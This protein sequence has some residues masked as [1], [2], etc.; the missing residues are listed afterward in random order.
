MNLTTK[1]ETATLGVFLRDRRARLAPDAGAVGHRRTPGLRREEV[2][3]R[4]GVSVTW[5]TWLEQGRGGPPSDEVL[6]RLARALELDAAGREALFLLGRQRPPPIEPTP[7]SPVTPAVQ[8]VLDGLATSP[9]FVKTAAWDVVAWNEAACVVFG[10]YDAIP[11]AERNGLR[12]LFGDPAHRARLP[13]WED[14]ARFAAGVLRLDVTRG[15]PDAVALAAE[16]LETNAEFRR[17]WGASEVRTQGSGL[18]RMLVQDAGL[19]VFDYA[20]FAI[21]AAPGL[22]MMVF[23]PLAA[24]DAATIAALVARRAER[25][26]QGAQAQ[27]GST[28]PFS[29]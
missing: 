4:A 15:F 3:A 13:D 23:S 16:L 14:I 28:Q 24:A 7:S 11:P 22:S 6:E 2:A 9:A 20:S 26:A 5:Y 18:K 27:A 10:D 21:D 1:P 8:R 29:S 12:R 19:L 17:V 25:V